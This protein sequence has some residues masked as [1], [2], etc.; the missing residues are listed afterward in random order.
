MPWSAEEL[1]GGQIQCECG[2]V[3]HVPI[4][5]IR[6]GEDVLEHLPEDVAHL[7]L[8]RR[9]I[10]VADETT[11][12]LAGRKVVELLE[13]DQI[14]TE[15]VILRPRRAFGQ[16]HWVLPDEHSLGQVLLAIGDEPCFLVA[17]GAGTIND[18]VR[19]VAHRTGKAFISVG[20]A[21]SMDGYASTVS[22]LLT[23][24]F[25]KTVPATYPAAI[26][27]DA[28]LLATAPLEMVAAGFGDLVGKSVAMADW[29]LSH[30]LNGEYYCPTIHS[31]VEQV[32]QMALIDVMALRQREPEALV[33]LTEGLVL[34][35]LAILMFNDSRP[36]SGAEHELA[37]FWEIRGIP[38]GK[39]F[40]HGAKV[41]VATPIITKFYS[42]LL[43]KDPNRI[44]WE[45]V[46][47][48]R[49]SLEQ[50]SR[51]LEQDFQ[52]AWQ[53]IA[54]AAWRESKAVEFARAS[55]EL[56]SDHWVEIQRRVPASLLDIE[57]IMADLRTLEAPATPR[58]LGL[59]REWVEAS[60]RSARE[61][62]P[63]R[64][65]VMDLAAEMGC[66]DEISEAVLTWIWP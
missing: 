37:H 5:T 27:I 33:R 6:S 63:H 64:Y 10:I 54:T 34:S 29:M 32:L 48:N 35:G 7:G 61:M 24:S 9:A 47:A 57:R 28:Q 31:I 58:E 8:P 39:L 50:Y 30:I 51:Q 44:D 43:A 62:K 55:G 13:A 60:L 18:I 45:Q 2:R 23:G 16:R 20:T 46:G 17:V 41:A 42:E 65:T 12:D 40:Y 52:G 26:Y 25:K 22:A 4:H 15:E 59:E 66:L 56:L 49:P 38:E 3:H 36:V 11:Y 21:P 19:F 53:S 14:T 1:A